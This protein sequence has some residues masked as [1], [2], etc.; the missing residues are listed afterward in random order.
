[1][2]TGIA[3]TTIILGLSLASALAQPTPGQKKW[4]ISKVDT[5]KFPPAST[6]QGVTFEKDIQPLIKASCLKCHSGARP[7]A[8]FKL[9]T[10]EN[11]L[12]GGRDGVMVIAGDSTNSLLVAAISRV[13]PRLAMPPPP[14]GG[15]P[16]SGNISPPPTPGVTAGDATAAAAAGGG[17]GTPPPPP[18]LTKDEV[19]LVRAWIDQGA[20]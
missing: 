9:D 6:Q 20:K 10:L 12:K 5:S 3:F 4:D 8:G 19:G 7:R 17:A 2:K 16:A 11:V 14:R 18:P 13:S 1:M 15:R